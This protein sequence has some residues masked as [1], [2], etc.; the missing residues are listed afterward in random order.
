MAASATSAPYVYLFAIGNTDGANGDDYIFFNPNLGRAVISA[1]DPGF[2]AEQGNSFGTLDAYNSNGVHVTVVFNVP[3]SIQV[4]TNGVQFGTVAGITDP[5]SVVGKEFAYIGQSLYTGDT[6]M[7]FTLDELRIYSGALD[8]N[9][10][11]ALQTAGPNNTVLNPKYPVTIAH[12]TNNVYN[13]TWPYIASEWG[14][15]LLSSTNIGISGGFTPV[16]NVPVN[17][18]AGNYQVQITATNTAKYYS[19]GK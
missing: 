7:N 10:V 4:Y 2:N 5:L 18:G 6:Y 16:T 12:V 3:G 1:T 9:S 17:I 11:A 19:L 13:I 14:Y 8:A 15:G